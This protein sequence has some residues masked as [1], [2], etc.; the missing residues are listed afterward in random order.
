MHSGNHEAYSTCDASRLFFNVALVATA[1][2]M[3]YLVFSLIV[4]FNDSL[5]NTAAGELS[6]SLWNTTSPVCTKRKVNADK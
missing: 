3:I 1:I 6:L 2:V 4:E 5:L